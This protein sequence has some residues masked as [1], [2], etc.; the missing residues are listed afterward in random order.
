MSTFEL[1][2]INWVP[3]RA[4][5]VHVFITIDCLSSVPLPSTLLELE[6]GSARDTM[7]M[8][9]SQI[10]GFIWKSRASFFFFTV[11]RLRFCALTGHRQERNLGRSG[12]SV[13]PF[14]VKTPH[15]I[16]IESEHVRESCSCP[17][18]NICTSGPASWL[19]IIQVW[20]ANAEQLTVSACS[21]HNG[22][23]WSSCLV[24]LRLWR[25]NPDFSD[26]SNGTQL[27]IK[28][29][30]LSPVV[31]TYSPTYGLLWEPILSFAPLLAERLP[32]RGLSSLRNHIIYFGWI[33]LNEN[34]EHIFETH[35]RQLYQST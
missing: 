27:Q 9:L 6:T 21:T 25:Q 20:L 31:S 18:G 28:E 5:H 17:H 10:D 3:R 2:R 12:S 30:F 14:R 13:A 34:D 29:A 35:F 32:F 19:A 22:D 11:Q 7:K 23:P 26:T 33:F 1:K 8:C 15:Q 4:T 24:S 16:H